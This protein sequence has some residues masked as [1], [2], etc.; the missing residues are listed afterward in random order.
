MKQKSNFFRN[1]SLILELITRRDKW[2]LFGLLIATFV[3]TFVETFGVSVIMPFITLATNPD[4]ILKNRVSTFIYHLLGFHSTNAFMITFSVLLVLFYVFRALYNTAYT[5]LINRFLLR[6]SHY[7]S[8]SIFC[9]TIR[10]DYEE[11]SKKNLDVIRKNIGQETRNASQFLSSFLNIF[12]EINIILLLYVLLLV[13]SWKMTLVLT[14]LLAVNI[15]LLVNG[16]GKVLD[17]QGSE[18]SKTEA[19]FMKMI[20]QILGN[21]KIVKLRAKEEENFKVFEQISL[22]QINIQMKYQTINT[23][24]RNILE[25]VGFCVLVACVGYILY[26]YGNAS[27]VLPIVSMYALALYRIL[28]S[29]TKILGHYN[30]MVFLGKSVEQVY[31][32]LQEEEDI[33]EGDEQIDFKDKIE[34]RGVAFAYPEKKEVISDYSLEIKHGERVAFVGKSGVGKST[35]VDLIIGILKPKRGE[36][37]VDGVKIDDSNIK[38]WRRKIGYIPQNIYLF[39]GS[40][41]ENIAFGSKM[42]KARL[43][44]VA[45]MARI[46]D[47][48]EEND[49][50]D[51]QVGDG[52]NALSGGQK[53]R[54]GIARALY[55]DPD[56]LVLDEATSALDTDTES[57]IMDEIYQ[58]AEDKTLLVIAHRLS[59]IERCDRRIVMEKPQ[60]SALE[61][62]KQAENLEQEK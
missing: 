59:T 10:Q 2:I 47:F 53:Q 48:L 8:Y 7:F 3:L 43:T 35:L 39:D 34:L 4:L 1:I 30:T 14:S 6:K 13:V 61:E 19:S 50:F 23:L 55:H 5:Y 27:A 51:T 52:G 37:F 25:M 44:K 15:F 26:S 32:V 22:K 33:F 56:V 57:A 42:D 41:G 62:E 16:L 36:I 46:Y 12:A 31:A 45:K 58:I 54:I 9:K 29:I 21:F 18:R 17:R 11:F 20:S 38:S 40:V 60:K 24:P 28:P 49:G